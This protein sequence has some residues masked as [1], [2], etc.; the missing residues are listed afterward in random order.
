MKNNIQ[1]DLNDQNIQEVSA[2]HIMLQNYLVLK[3]MLKNIGASTIVEYA[4]SLLKLHDIGLNPL[5]FYKKMCRLLPELK[6][7][8]ITRE[9]FEK[10]DSKKEVDLHTKDVVHVKG[11]LENILDLNKAMV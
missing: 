4:S 3:A 8:Q 7:D 11:V 6:Y 2:M 9:F 1:K 10:I 5:V